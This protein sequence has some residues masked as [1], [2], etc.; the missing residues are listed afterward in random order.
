MS[1]LVL[2]ENVHLPS[3]W[4]LVSLDMLVDIISGFAFKSNNFCKDGTHVVKISNI[5]YGKY[6][7]KN[8]KYL[9]MTYLKRYPS[10]V[11]QPK[12]ILM[13]L[14][15]PITNNTLKICEY[16]E[17]SSPALLNQRVCTFKIS[18]FL[19]HDFFKYFLSTENFKKQVLSIMSQTLQPNLSPIKLQK[20]SI[21]LIA[22][23]EQKKIVNKI[24]EFLS[25][26]NHIKTILENN[27]LQLKQYRQSLLSNLLQGLFLKHP[28]QKLND[29]CTKISDGTHF[30]P[31]YTPN[32]V[33][34]I[35]VKDI[36]NEKIHFDDC[37]YVSKKTHDTLIKRCNPEFGD[38]LITKSGTIGRMA[39]ID[40]K[41]PFSLFVSVALIKPTKNINRNYLKYIFQNYFNHLDISQQIKGGVI[42]NFHLE[43]IREVMIPM[44]TDDEQQEIVIELEQKFSI[45][46]NTENIIRSTLLKLDTLNSSVLK[47]A[48][49]GKLVPQDPND[50]PV[51]I[52]LQKIK[53]EQQL[54]QKQKASRSTKNVK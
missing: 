26:L 19:N 50:E 25:E 3:N 4:K 23:N 21:P 52:L 32:G 11:I 9:P 17:N 43:D 54:I 36:R 40:T 41:I 44:P 38:L 2:E 28:S 46:N 29:L 53:Q 12:M 22:L 16:P 27:L 31:E 20:L 6:V 24:E 1:E 14:T 18:K 30:T 48:F 42:K 10:F 51:K 5:G 45:I 47:K 35:S 34:F 33:P 37:K 15:R 13:A 7:N 49:E 8:Q 39:L